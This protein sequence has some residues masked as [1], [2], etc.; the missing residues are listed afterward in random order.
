M[1]SLSGAAFTK[2]NK[3][4]GVTQQTC[5][6]SQFRKLAVQSQDGGRAMLPLKA[7]GESFAS[8][9]LLVAC[10]QSLTFL[11]LQPHD[12]FSAVNTWHSLSVSLPSRGFLLK[13]TPP[14]VGLGI[15]STPV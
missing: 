4:D 14:H 2:Y 3:L 7:V 6:V 9:P 5:I 1:Y 8:R 11:G 12:S 10:Q 15:R 13:R